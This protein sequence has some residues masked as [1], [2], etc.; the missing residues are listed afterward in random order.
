MSLIMIVTIQLPLL[1]Q[2]ILLFGVNSQLA[3]KNLDYTDQVS[4]NFVFSNL[5]FE[6]PKTATKVTLHIFTI[7]KV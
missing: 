7:L 3:F 6:K 2:L 4:S 1:V 5:I